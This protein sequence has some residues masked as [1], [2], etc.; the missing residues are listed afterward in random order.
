MRTASGPTH[1]NGICSYLCTR[2]HVCFSVVVYSSGSHAALV[3]ISCPPN[4]FCFAMTR[5]HRFFC[6]LRTP[7]C[8]KCRVCRPRVVEIVL[9]ALVPEFLKGRQT[10]RC[11]LH[12]QATGRWSSQHLAAL[13]YMYRTLYCNCKEKISRSKQDVVEKKKKQAKKTQKRG[14]TSDAPHNKQA[15]FNAEAMAG[16]GLS[17]SSPV[18]IVLKYTPSLLSAHLMSYHRKTLPTTTQARRSPQNHRRSTLPHPS[19]TSGQ[20]FVEPSHAWD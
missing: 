16:P 13:V 1:P 14:S 4:C 18:Q 10:Q 11:H 2:V 6:D 5:N 3:H 12:T 7:S 15:P 8:V 9:I 17:R 20:T 19:G